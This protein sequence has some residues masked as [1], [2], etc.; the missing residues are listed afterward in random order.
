MSTE[1][2]INTLYIAAESE[3]ELPKKMLLRMAAE[4]LEDLNS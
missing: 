4:R 1:E 3:P 2:L